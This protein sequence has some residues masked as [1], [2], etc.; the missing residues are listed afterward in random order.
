MEVG[1]AKQSPCLEFKGE[2]TKERVIP[3]TL[4]LI[5]VIFEAPQAR[6][7]AETEE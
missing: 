1:S 4:G 7:P 5:W 6:N 3:E 2:I